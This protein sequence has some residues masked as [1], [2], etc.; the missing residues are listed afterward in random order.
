MD[1]GSAVV[2]THPVF[3]RPPVENARRRGRKPASVGNIERQRYKRLAA[4]LRQMETKTHYEVVT[5][6][7][8]AALLLEGQSDPEAALP[9]AIAGAIS[10]R[11]LSM[12]REAYELF[13]MHLQRRVAYEAARG[14][15]GEKYVDV[16]LALA[17]VSACNLGDALAHLWLRRL[18]F[19]REQVEMAVFAGQRLLNDM[20]A[21]PGIRR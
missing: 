6:P 8:P 1:K 10:D 16:E 18:D 4:Y 3:D 19:I 7:D 17:A 13:H 15:T 11:A 2:L 20:D 14:C 5:A 21:M 12:A 9:P